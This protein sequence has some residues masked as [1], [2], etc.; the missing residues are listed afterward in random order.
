VE[1]IVRFIIVWCTERSEVYPHYGVT[2]KVIYDKERQRVPLKV[3][4][5]NVEHV[6]LDQAQDAARLPVT[7]GSV[8]LLPDCPPGLRP[9]G[10]RGARH[11]TGIVSRWEAVEQTYAD[12]QLAT[13]ECSRT[14]P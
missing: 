1:R 9:A 8:V 5:E 7:R 4:A 6:A 13:T 2:M 10:G 12:G 3:F 11:Y 14:S